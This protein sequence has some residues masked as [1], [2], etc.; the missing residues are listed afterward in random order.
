MASI[1]LTGDTSGEITI[2]APAVAGTNT[3]TLPAS[4]S[5]IATTDDTGIQMADQ[6]RLTANTNTSTNADVTTNWERV[7]NSE[8][9]GIG[10]GLT[11]SSG[12]FSFPATGIYFLNYQARISV[13]AGDV[14]AN[15]TLAVTEDNSSYTNVATLS[16]GEQG[17]HSASNNFLIDVTDTSNVKFKF[18][19]GSFNTGTF[20]SGETTQSRT[21]FA[22][23]KLGD[24]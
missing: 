17:T 8:W 7:D 22:I 11:E 2:S 20:L 23:F 18:I 10:T 13:V 9:G 6:W 16:A 14:I 3:L 5:T 21:G 1:K 15:Y 12:I 4:T 24:T 19:T